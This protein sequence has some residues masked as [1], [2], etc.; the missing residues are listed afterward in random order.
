MRRKLLLHYHMFKNAGTSVDRLLRESYG[1]Q[2]RNY[3][4]DHP[5]ALISSDEILSYI[6][7]NPQLKALSSHQIVPPVPTGDVD[8]LPIVFIRDPI[9][10]IRSAWLFEWKKQPGLDAP[11]GPLS[12]YIEERLQ[13]GSGNVIRDFQV[14]RLSNLRKD[15]VTPD[16]D[17]HEND[18]LAAAI[19][20][21]QSIPFFGLVERFDESLALLESHAA[22]DFPDLVYH[23]YQENVTRDLSVTANENFDQFKA[24]VGD[25]LF[26]Q[27][28]LRN[29][30]DLQLYSYAQ[31]LFDARLVMTGVT[32]ST[33][34][35]EH[36]ENTTPA[37]A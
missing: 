8:I 37:V 2:W 17:V 25:R 20:F 26:D 22:T 13:P 9:Q 34:E 5:A 1:E 29:R 11:K 21:L 23:R 19:N 14:S 31:G 30:L 27:V 36:A 35:H 7:A 4:K 10:R 12:A 33:A 18:R 16:D 28:I 32:G 3:D 15:S 24:E 6:K